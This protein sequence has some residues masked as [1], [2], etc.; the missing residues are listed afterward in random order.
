MS[1]PELFDPG[2]QPERTDL[3]WRRSSLAMIIDSLIALRILPPVLGPAGLAA[4]LGGL[5]IAGLVWLLARRRARRIQQSLRQR[6]TLPGAGLLLGVTTLAAG[7]AA[8][9]LLYV[10]VHRIGLIPQ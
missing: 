1:E 6:T 3:A 9:G 7:G 10:A 4:A 8:V 2:L 5:L